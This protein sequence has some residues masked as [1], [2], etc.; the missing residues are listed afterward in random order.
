MRERLLTI[1]VN[2][3][4]YKD[5]SEFY[6]LFEVI[7]LSKYTSIADDL[8]DQILIGKYKDSDKLPKQADLADLYHT[9]RVTISRAIGIL[10]L[11][12]LLSTEFGGGT[13]INRINTEN[14]FFDHMINTP[15]GASYNYGGK[16]QLTSTIVSFEQR[17]PVE[18]EQQKLHI[19]KTDAVYD[20]IRVRNLNGQPFIIEYTIMPVKVIPNIT[21]EILKDSIYAHIQHT[22]KLDLGKSFRIIS[23]DE[24]DAFDSQY[25][26]TEVGKPILEI[27]QVAFL[28]NGLPF[29]YSQTRHLYNKGR[30]IYV[31]LYR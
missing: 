22:L 5:V 3:S 28:K 6:N 20:I 26:Q 8:R 19:K 21:M 9:S 16:G 27:E 17:L 11:E 14:Q 7:H 2:V 10:Q 25:L 18:V 30:I 29:E 24:A 12:G 31:E 4:V 13:K 15:S 1:F 23:A